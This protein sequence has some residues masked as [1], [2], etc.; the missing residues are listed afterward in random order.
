MKEKKFTIIATEKDGQGVIN[1]EN[2]GFTALEIL[3]ILKAKEND[4]LEQMKMPADFKR[5]TIDKN[6][7]RSEI[8]KEGEE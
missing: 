1:T 7:K 2:E 3:G 6:G 5:Y 4:I 8:V